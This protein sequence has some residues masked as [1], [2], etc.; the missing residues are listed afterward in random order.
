MKHTAIV[1][2]GVLSLLSKIALSD[3]N[4]VLGVQDGLVLRSGVRV[5]D[6]AYPFT[7]IKV[8]GTQGWFASIWAGGNSIATDVHKHHKIDTTIGRRVWSGERCHATM[9]FTH[10]FARPLSNNALHSFIP[11]IGG[12]CALDHNWTVS[13]NALGVLVPAEPKF[14]GYLT[15][16]SLA[17]STQMSTRL[18][19]GMTG[20]IGYDGSY[21]LTR[22]YVAAS[23]WG[24]YK[25]SE[26]M[27][28][29]AGIRAWKPDGDRHQTSFG[30][31]LEYH[32][33]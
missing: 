12:M 5:A 7:H 17:G 24:T 14:N 28:L 33:N 16:V 10:S 27:S 25:L 18:D 31:Q 30:L 6:G 11:S 22:P 15:N 2:M 26:S 23:L 20:A 8:S 9:S 21:G 1:M 3:T 19:M 13:A 32:F 29:R 4:V